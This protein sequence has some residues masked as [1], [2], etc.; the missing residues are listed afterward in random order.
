MNPPRYR[1]VAVR[2]PRLIAGTAVMTG[3]LILSVEWEPLARVAEP[4]FGSPLL[5][6]LA[7]GVLMAAVVG[8]G[9]PWAD[10][11]ISDFGIIRREGLIFSLFRGAHAMPWEAIESATVMEEMDGSRSLTLRT[12]HGAEWKVWEKFGT[13]G[14]FDAFRQEVTTRLERRPRGPPDAAPV[15]LRSAWDGAAARIVVAALAAGW[16][17]LAVLTIT[18][19]AAG[20]SVRIAKLLALALLLAPMLYRAFFVR[21]TQVHPGG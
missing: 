21:R 6:L 14:G 16:L 4:V 7:I 19:P 1:S 17:V 12:K 3:L 18:G 13:R 5:A 9:R 11:Q 20:R 2:W 10:Y 8:V 15:A